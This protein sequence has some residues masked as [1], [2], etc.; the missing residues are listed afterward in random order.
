LNLIING[1]DSSKKF[2]FIPVL[3][4]GSFEDKTV[5]FFD[6]SRLYY[7]FNGNTKLT[8]ITQV[9][10]ENGLLRQEFKKIQFGNS[11]FQH[12]WS[13]SMA[14]A[15][16]NF[17]LSEQEKLKKQMES[18]TLKEV[19]VR[20]RTKSPLQL[21]DEKY[22]TGMFSGGDGTSFDLTSDPSASSAIDV[23]SYL[24]G[25]VAGLNISVLGQQVSATWR[26]SKTEFFLNEMSTPIETIQTLNASDIAYIKVI[27]PPFFG[28]V[29]GGSGGAIAIYSKR[30][31]SNKGSNMNSKGMEN[32]I[33]GGY[34]VFKEFYNPNYEKLPP[35]YDP[36]N[37]STIYWNPYV[38]TN[39]RNQRV[40]IEF[41]NN[42][43]TK[44]QQIVLEGMNADG[45]LVRVVK[46]IE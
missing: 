38:L 31:N 3:K 18:A 9:H 25:K 21:L 44:K 23:L 1:K 14:R 43:Y 30:G 7:G 37:R 12:S 42:D 17:Y 41:Y 33:L 5:Y 40:R 36:D 4:D 22:A 35:N 29:G 19:V 13:D 10:F 46:Y 8:D 16:L 24:Q 32:T 2:L 34:S 45:K 28:S 39:K 27:R 6:T 15:K 26:G 20:A 11:G